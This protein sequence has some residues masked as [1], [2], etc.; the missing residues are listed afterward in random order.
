MNKH[1]ISVGPR[2]SKEDFMAAIGLEANNSYHEQY[3]RL[4]R[5]SYFKFLTLSVLHCTTGTIVTDLDNQG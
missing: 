5:V 1:S 3:Y 4:M 2:A